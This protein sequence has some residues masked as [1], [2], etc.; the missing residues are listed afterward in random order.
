M[1]NK[2]LQRQIKDLNLELTV[3]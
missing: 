2:L 1:E 3:S